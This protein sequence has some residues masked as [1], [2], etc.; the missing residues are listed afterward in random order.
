MSILFLNF[1]K[2]IWTSWLSR[3]FDVAARN[4]SL[5]PRSL[6]LLR[7]YVYFQTNM[8]Q[9]LD[10]VAPTELCPGFCDETINIALLTEL[11]DEEPSFEPLP[12]PESRDHAKLPRW[13]RRSDD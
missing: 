5:S 12:A 11:N 8:T 2:K 13:R 10:H 1:F 4:L 9:K 3:F 7:D 6:P